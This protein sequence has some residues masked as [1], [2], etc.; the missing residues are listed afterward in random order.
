LR[1]IGGISPLAQT[2]ANQYLS[3]VRA[4]VE[5]CIALLKNWKILATGYSRALRKPS[6][7][8][9]RSPYSNSIDSTGSVFE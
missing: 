5:R 4:A 9:P 8:P 2:E 7:A 3:D 1:R 6:S